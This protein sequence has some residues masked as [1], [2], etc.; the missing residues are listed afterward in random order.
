MEVLGQRSITVTSPH[1]PVA[2]FDGDR[3]TNPDG[4]DIEYLVSGLIDP[5]DIDNSLVLALLVAESM[6]V[7]ILGMTRHRLLLRDRVY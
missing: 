6:A 1:H 3:W 2:V 5:F 4:S 7:Q